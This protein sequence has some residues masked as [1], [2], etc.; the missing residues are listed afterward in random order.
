MPLNQNN[1]TQN[2]R[3]PLLRKLTSTTLFANATPQLSLPLL[4]R[5]PSPTILQITIFTV[6]PIMEAPAAMFTRNLLKLSIR[7]ADLLGRES[8]VRVSHRFDW[9]ITL[10]SS[11]VPND[12][13]IL[14]FLSHCLY[15]YSTIVIWVIIYFHEHRKNWEDQPNAAGAQSPK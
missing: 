13:Y 10:S 1:Q 15:S 7:G 11:L 9:M 12:I 14:S 5:R 2:Q 3:A 4:P 8:W 6:A